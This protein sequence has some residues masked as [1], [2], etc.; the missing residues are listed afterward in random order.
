[1]ANNRSNFCIQTGGGSTISSLPIRFVVRNDGKVNIG[2]SQTKT[3]AF[4]VEGASNFENTVTA[5]SFIGP[6]TGNSSTATKIDSI[7][8][9]NIVQLTDTQ[10]LTNK[11]WTSPTVTGVLFFTGSRIDL[12]PSAGSSAVIQSH[13]DGGRYTINAEHT[14]GDFQIY[15]NDNSVSVMRY[16]QA[17]QSITFNADVNIPANSHYKINGVNIATTDTTYA[18]PSP[19]L[20][21]SG[22]TISLHTDLTSV[23][24]VQSVNNTD[25]KL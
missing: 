5:T 22:T 13:S 23:N 14:N 17:S 10:T 2:S 15:D 6:L 8:N 9:S 3:H 20:Q 16:F 12:E 25:L 11:S 21:T 7:I 4:N 18:F 19:N 1:M 24:S